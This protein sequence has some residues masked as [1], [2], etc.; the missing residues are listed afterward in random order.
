MRGAFAIRALYRGMTRDDIS[1]ECTIE[2]NTS[3]GRQSSPVLALALAQGQS[4]EFHPKSVAE[5]KEKKGKVSGRTALH[6]YQKNLC[7]LRE[8][9]DVLQNVWKQIKTRFLSQCFRRKEN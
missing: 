5:R 1:W 7:R 8:E 6:D 4:G 2:S 9:L 3:G